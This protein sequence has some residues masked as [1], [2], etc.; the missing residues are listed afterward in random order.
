MTAAKKP[1]EEEDDVLADPFKEKTVSQQEEEQMRQAI[2]ASKSDFGPKSE[3][4]DPAIQQALLR[5]LESSYTLRSYV[6]HRG[7]TSSTGHYIAC[8]M[9]DKR[10]KWIKFNDAISEETVFGSREEESEGYLF[11][12]DTKVPATK[13]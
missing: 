13:K 7:Y 11:F 4:D 3:E 6:R 8:V 9:D 5:S 2:E 12:Y 1:D 10:K